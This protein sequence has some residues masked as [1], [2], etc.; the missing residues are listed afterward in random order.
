MAKV[1][2]VLLA[3]TLVLYI[4]HVSE[5]TS[6]LQMF[7]CT[8]LNQSLTDLDAC[9]EKTTTYTI[10]GKDPAILAYLCCL[11]YFSDVDHDWIRHLD[12][13]FVVFI[14]DQTSSAI[15]LT[16]ANFTVTCSA[17]TSELL[18]LTQFKHWN[19]TKSARDC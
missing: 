19:V 17:S 2:I 18:T 13:D 16:I 6:D 10:E 9:Y 7:C 15:L 3:A 12:D 8:I 1:V 11:G 4:A 14:S 5:C